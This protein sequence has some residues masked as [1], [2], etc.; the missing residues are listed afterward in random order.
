ME[1]YLLEAALLMLAAYLVGAILGCVL[2]RALSPI[3]SASATGPPQLAT[4]T[5]KPSS[6]A[7]A[8]AASI[9]EAPEPVQPRIE[10][11]AHPTPPQEAKVA[12]SARFERA[13]TSAPPAAAASA[14]AAAAARIQISN[15]TPAPRLPA[16]SSG[17]GTSAVAAPIAAPA[18]DLRKINGIDAGTANQLNQLG[19]TRFSQI[20]DWTPNDISRVRTAV[21]VSSRHS[22]SW[23]EQAKILANGKETGYLRWLSDG[24]PTSP[25]ALAGVATAAAI[26]ATT[27]APAAIDPGPADLSRIEGVDQNTAELLSENG[28]TS[29]GQIARWT[30]GDVERFDTLLQQRGRVSRQNWIEQAKI[31]ADGK[32]TAFN[33]RMSMAPTPV[34]APSG[35]LLAPQ[36]LAASIVSPR[37]A[38]VT[39]TTAA[40]AAPSAAG[41]VAEASTKPDDLKLIRGVDPNAEKILHGE[42]IGTFA[43]LAAWRSADVH[44]IDSLL[45]QPGR[46]SEQNWIEQAKILADGNQTAF[47]TRQASRPNVIQRPGSIAAAGGIAIA[48]LRGEP[49]PPP[50]PVEAAPPTTAPVIKHAPPEPNSEFPQ[51]ETPGEQVPRPARLA[52]AIRQNAA[53]LGTTGAPPASGVTGMR[54]VRSQLLSG[55]ETAKPDVSDD[56]KKIRGIG[57]LIEKK[58][59]AM[60][61][62]SYEQIA[63]WSSEEIQRVSSALDFKGRIERE[64]WVQQARILAS[65]GQTE[66]SKRLN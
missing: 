49:P 61:V 6:P 14:A 13:L 18:D 55:E 59:N 28:I 8:A 36:P 45:A 38:A 32:Q 47:V 30:T 15:P 63:N 20:A 11:V 26:A 57:V 24:A 7:A 31:L 51:P 35:G 46:A 19:Y 5:A 58:L 40:T 48:A 44:N 1:H 60:G 12:E 56:L 25:W 10:T 21:G 53:S 50:A 65:G 33:R 52:D 2:R 3:V 4:K 27:V 43:Q 42:G 17:T 62:Y 41:A 39:A 9:R 66:F 23:I 16:A 29:Y 34:T 22:G 54:S 64:G 37:S